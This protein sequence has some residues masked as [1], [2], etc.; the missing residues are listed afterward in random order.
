MQKSLLIWFESYGQMQ[1]FS[2][3]SQ[4]SRSRSQSPTLWYDVNA[5]VTGKTHV[6]YESPISYGL[7]VMAKVNVLTVGQTFKFKVTKLNIMVQCE[8]FLTVIHLCIM[9]APTCLF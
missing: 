6:Q 3:V 4:I 5:H 7:K 1:A 2:K 9:K 8:L